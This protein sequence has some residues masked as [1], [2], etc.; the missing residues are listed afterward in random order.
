MFIKLSINYLIANDIRFDGLSIDSFYICNKFDIFSKKRVPEEL[1]KNLTFDSKTE[2]ILNDKF[3]HKFN[4]ELEKWSKN[5]K[6]GRRL[7][8]SGFNEE[9]I[10]ITYSEFG[11]RESDICDEMP[12]SFYT[13]VLKKEEDNFSIKV[14]TSVHFN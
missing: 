2:Q 6:Y 4:S 7:S 5:K 12:S 9:W 10:M 14:G 11:D 13:Y 8:V 3:F 1:E